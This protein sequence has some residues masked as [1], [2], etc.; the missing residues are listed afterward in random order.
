[1]AE[2]MGELTI[3][4]NAVGVDKSVNSLKR[5][6]TGL[7]KAAN[8]AARDTKTL[9]A[10][11]TKFGGAMSIVTASITAASAGLLAQ[12]PIMQE[13]FG[14]LGFLVETLAYT[15]DEVLRPVLQPLSDAIYNLSTAFL[16]LPGPVQDAVAWIAFLSAIILPII[17]GIAAL[18]V[19]ILAG[20]TAAIAFGVAVAAVVTTLWYLLPIIGL[21]V[22]A[23]YAWEKNWLGIQDV[24]DNVASFISDTL[25]A[26][27]HTIVSIFSAIVGWIDA[28]FGDE[29]RAT[30][31]DLEATFSFWVGNIYAL[32]KL[33]GSFFVWLYETVIRPIFN[34]IMK[35]L[36]PVIDI[37]KDGLD[38]LI[39]V[40]SV[41]WNVIKSGIEI[42]WSIIETIVVTA[43]TNLLNVIQLVLAL[44][45]G[46]W[47]RAWQEAKSIMSSTVSGIVSIIGT[48]KDAFLGIGISLVKG[49]N[50]VIDSIN[51]ISVK[52]DDWVPIYG[53]KEFKMNIPKIPIPSLRD[54]GVIS[55]S[56]IAEVHSGEAVFTMETLTNAFINAI[57]LSGMDS[58]REPVIYLDGRRLARAIGYNN[59]KDMNAVGGT[60]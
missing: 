9:S 15:M 54:Q 59:D 4:V 22:L 16:A 37:I 10:F 27:Y 12:M 49:L 40:F 43:V 32:L 17:G 41:A 18:V 13:M 5:A 31:A 6:Q 28:N 52:I 1:M 34:A 53:G 48:L 33:L 24:I 45:R 55:R 44:L 30:L 26:I 20:S 60:F 51:S 7:G 47:G 50:S 25:S 11:A 35:V 39:D 46:D 58:G 36:D 42:V 3:L 38:I 2:K 8:N 29:I 21:I 57:R 14:G 19:G 23:I 56:G